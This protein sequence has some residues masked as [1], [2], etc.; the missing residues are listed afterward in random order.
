MGNDQ[1]RFP[2][3][4]TLLTDNIHTLAQSPFGKT[5]DGQK[6]VNVLNRLKKEGKIVF[7]DMDDRGDEEGD[8]IRINAR[9]YSNRC[10]V[11][12][13]LAHEG[14]HMEWRAQHPNRDSSDEVVLDELRC[15]LIELE[16]YT[17]AKRALSCSVS[18][19]DLDLRLDYLDSPPKGPYP[20]PGI[21]GDK[22]YLR[23][24]THIADRYRPGAQ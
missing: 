23:L 22:K 8:T 21:G 5:F 12:P 6:I 2:D 1:D 17:W 3:A 18:D 11:I 24:K 9:F 19:P 10:R 13:V 15:E 4:D 16:I 20:I 14:A 7:A